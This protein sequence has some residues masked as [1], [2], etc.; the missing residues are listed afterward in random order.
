MN[1]SN[2]SSSVVV[3]EGYTP[4]Q[5]DVIRRTVAKDASNLELQMFLHLAKKYDLDPF[6]RE[7]WCINMAGTVKIITARDGYLKIAS[8]NPHFKGLESDVVYENDNF[9]KQND[10]IKH[11]YQ[12]VNRGNIVGAYALVYRDDRIRPSY[13]FAPMKDY[14]KQKNCWTQ[15]PHAMIVK[16]AE[17]MALKRAFPIS[18]LCTVEELTA[19]DKPNISDADMKKTRINAIWN[20]Y[21]KFFRSSSEAIEA[22]KNLVGDK[23]SSTWTAQDMETL[24]QALTNMREDANV[25]PEMAEM[26]Q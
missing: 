1:S 18:G 16:V 25:L 12:A 7:I 9:T 20:G 24:E 4:Q 26:A 17:S 21:R 6:A 2:N 22:M 8:S 13:F 14:D 5:V 3:Y 23:A 19:D 15:Y 11:S 10:Y